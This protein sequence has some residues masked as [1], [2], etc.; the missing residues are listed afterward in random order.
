MIHCA[1][2]GNSFVCKQIAQLRDSLTRK[3]VIA[4]VVCN[5]TPRT[6]WTIRGA[7]GGST[8]RKTVLKNL[9]IKKLEIKT[10]KLSYLG[11]KC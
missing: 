7:E 6:S 2:S 3:P 11:S 8:F 4:A 9:A 5:L 1:Q 10:I